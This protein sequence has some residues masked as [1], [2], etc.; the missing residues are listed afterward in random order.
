MKV[1]T[2]GGDKGETSLLGGYRLSK[3][4][5]RIHAYGTVDELNSHL[6]LLADQPVNRSRLVF[7]RNI[8]RNL[9]S[10]GSHLAAAAD[11]DKSKLPEIP[12]DLE[13]DL[14][15]AID[16]MESRLPKLRHFVLPGGHSSVS[17]CHIA[18]SVARRAER[19]VVE[20]HS[21]EPTKQS[22]IIYLNRLSDYLFVLAR[23]MAQEL[24]IQEVP[25][26]PAK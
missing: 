21:Q 3:S 25:W 5:T 10:I 6:G 9:F 22:I 8:Q 20:L 19:L 7:L 13:S 2:K 18:R 26:K 17:V 15:Q 14:E 11:F 23:M 4:N 12:A 16:D 1:Y 24:N